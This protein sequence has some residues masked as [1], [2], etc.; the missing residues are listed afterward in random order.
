MAKS[1]K[2]AAAFHA[3]LHPLDTAEQTFGCRHT[4][5]IICGKHSVPDVCAFVREDGICLAPP[6]SWPKQFIKLLEMQKK[7]T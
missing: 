7:A 3:P 5:P 6:R 2:Q 4:N 1:N